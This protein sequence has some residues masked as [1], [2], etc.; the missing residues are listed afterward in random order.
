MARTLTRR[1]TKRDTDAYS[2]ADEPEDEKGYDEEEEDER[3]AR[4]SR[5]G[6]RRASVNTQ[7]DKPSRRSRRAQD[8]D[9]EEE[10]EPPAKVG[11][12]GWGSYE[13]TKQATSNFPD[14]FKA[15]GEAVIVKFLD[16][17]PFLVYLQHWIERT[18][19][20]SFTCLENRCPLCDDLGDKPSQQV[21]FNIVDFTDPDD[22]QVKVW[23]A[24]PMIADILKNFANDRKTSPLNRDDLYFSVSKQTK[25]KKTNYYITPVKER[26]LEDDWDVAPLSE[27]ELTEFDDNAYGEDILQVS[28]RNELKTIAREALD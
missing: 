22:P 12:K 1:R 26:D 2:P 20:R 4:G 7:E 6:S 9:D 3:P 14:D 19:K 8:E 25:N 21:L 5:R 18:G 27:D 17:E 11:G 15:S 24:G 23:R 13:K 10:K 28:T 16:D